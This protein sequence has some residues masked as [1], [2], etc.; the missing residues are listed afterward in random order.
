LAG[1]V[2]SWG[3]NAR[4]QLGR[5]VVPGSISPGMVEGLEGVAINRVIA[6]EDHRFVCLAFVFGVLR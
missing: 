2:F 1:K 6:S 4:G 5:V 3:V